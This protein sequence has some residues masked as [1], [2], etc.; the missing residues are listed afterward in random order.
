[1]EEVQWIPKLT[2]EE[3]HRPG[4]REVLRQE[5][6][7]RWIDQGYD[8]G[9]SAQGIYCGH[10]GKFVDLTKDVGMCERAGW[11]FLG[12]VCCPVNCLTDCGSS[13]SHTNNENRDS[14]GDLCDVCLE[15]GVRGVPHSKKVFLVDPKETEAQRN[16]DFQKMIKKDF[17]HEAVKALANSR[18]ASWVKPSPSSPHRYVF[19][20]ADTNSYIVVIPNQEL[21]KAVA[22]VAIG[23]KNLPLT[24]AT[25]IDTLGKLL[26]S[27]WEDNMRE[28]W[29]NDGESKHLLAE[30]S[31]CLGMARLWPASLAGPGI[32][33][34]HDAM[35][36]LV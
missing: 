31:G 8:E 15:T 10:S 32:V 1:M 4:D 20:K 35:D 7:Q 36:D 25:K 17:S 34:M 6:L 9:S 16:A 24:E 23:P 29:V 21:K 3:C 27:R 12:I 30:W 22:Y 33:A 18:K 2:T 5:G 13:S 26:C 28:H 11:I 14:T 19:A